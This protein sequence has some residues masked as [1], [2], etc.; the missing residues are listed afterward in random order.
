MTH[1]PNRFRCQN[2]K[3]LLPKSIGKRRETATLSITHREYWR[4]IIPPI[5]RRDLSPSPPT[6]APVAKTKIGSR[7]LGQVQVASRS[8]CSLS[9]VRLKP[10]CICSNRLLLLLSRV[11]SRTQRP[12]S[13]NKKKL[14][15]RR[16]T[17]GRRSEAVFWKWS[18]SRFY[19]LWGGCNVRVSHGQIRSR[20]EHARDV[21]TG[22]GTE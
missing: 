9:R 4:I 1:R 6:H 3:F 12:E 17:A 18:L 19:Y 15:T 22:V 14:R 7:F 10:A 2:G 5:S 21:S 11:T 8:L 16:L 20:L 13:E